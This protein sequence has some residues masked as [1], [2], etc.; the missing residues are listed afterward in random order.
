MTSLQ[1][2]YEG[3]IQLANKLWIATLLTHA[4]DFIEVA[5]P[6][7][8]QNLDCDFAPLIFTLPYFGIPPLIQREV[9]PVVAKRDLDGVWK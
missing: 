2:L 8:L 1:N 7:Y 4:L 5:R 3:H 9:R 6:V